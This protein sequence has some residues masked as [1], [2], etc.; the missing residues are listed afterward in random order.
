[1]HAEP[2]HW[3]HETFILPKLFVTIFGL[4]L[5]MAGAQTLWDIA[6]VINYFKALIALLWLPSR[7][8]NSKNSSSLL[9]L[10]AHPGYIQE[11]FFKNAP[12]GHSFGGSTCFL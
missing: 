12:V 9:I 11:F 2:S 8:H 3:L 4:E 1:V 7:L 5:I 10:V 6:S